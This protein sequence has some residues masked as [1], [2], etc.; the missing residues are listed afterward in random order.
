[1]IQ[2]QIKAESAYREMI[3]RLEGKDEIKRQAKLK[4]ALDAFRKGEPS[5]DYLE[6]AA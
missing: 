2:E 1:M 4:K 5:A 3:R 6:G